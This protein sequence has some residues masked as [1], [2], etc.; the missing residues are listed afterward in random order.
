[1]FRGRADGR[2]GPKFA[3][4][5]TPEDASALKDDTGLRAVAELTSIHG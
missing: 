2:D 1:M 3:A 4:A 5:S